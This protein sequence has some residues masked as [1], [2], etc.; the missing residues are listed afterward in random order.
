MKLRTSFKFFLFSQILGIGFLQQGFGIGFTSPTLSELLKLGL[1]DDTT[2]PIFTSLFVVGL[3]L[4]S[5]LSIPG[6]KYLGRKMVSILSSLPVTFGWLLIAVGTNF[7]YLLAGR[8]FHGI[9]AGMIAT[10][11]PVYL[12]EI[13][14]P[15]ARG[16]WT[17]FGGVYDVTGTFIVYLVGVFVSFRWLYSGCCVISVAHLCVADSAREPHVALL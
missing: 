14:P 9:G 4:G 13:T 1:L 8:F 3:A 11:I 12:G 16:F 10:V 2:Y 7:G 17:G 5:I 15:A 6:S